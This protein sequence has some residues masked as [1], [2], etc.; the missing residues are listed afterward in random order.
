M[1]A[2][3]LDLLSVTLGE[4]TQ[5]LDI[6]PAGLPVNLIEGGK[7]AQSR[8]TVGRGLHLSV[9]EEGVTA[10]KQPARALPDGNTGM[11]G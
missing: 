8:G 1:G 4:L 5:A 6:P 3:Q 11:T 9:M 7:G 10:V 2:D